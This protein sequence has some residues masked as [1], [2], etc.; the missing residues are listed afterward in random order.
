MFVNKTPLYALNPIKSE[1][2]QPYT[3][4]GCNLKSG[5]TSIS[6]FFVLYKLEDTKETTNI[7]DTITAVATPCWILHFTPRSASSSA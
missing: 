4:L 1:S 5:K 2:L 3:W 6:K 7:Q